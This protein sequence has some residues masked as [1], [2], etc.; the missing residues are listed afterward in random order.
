M[1]PGSKVTIEQAL[2][3]KRIYEA[4]PSQTIER[5][6]LDHN[7]GLSLVRLWMK[8]VGTEFREP[9]KSGKKIS[10]EKIIPASRARDGIIGKKPAERN[11]QHVSQ[12]KIYQGHRRRKR[13]G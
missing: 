6:A 9:T 5:I 11:I 8:K 7:R 3:W 12:N 13:F 4:D 1:S 10:G 2:E